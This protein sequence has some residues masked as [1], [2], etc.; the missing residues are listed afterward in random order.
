MQFL[1]NLKFQYS[2]RSVSSLNVDLLFTAN[3]YM[4]Q[5]TKT[6]TNVTIDMPSTTDTAFSS[7]IALKKIGGELRMPMIMIQNHL[8]PK[9]ESALT[10][11]S[12]TKELTIFP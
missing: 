1:P 8:L 12:I 10:P 6:T 7:L 4:H 9:T 3:I 2:L 5:A 11:K